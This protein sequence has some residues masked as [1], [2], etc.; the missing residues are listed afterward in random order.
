[1]LK[2]QCKSFGIPYPMGDDILTLGFIADVY[3][4]QSNQN[5]QRADIL[6]IPLRKER[7]T[8]VLMIL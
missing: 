4:S 7:T 1:M 5:E 3:G 2:K 8:E 6:N